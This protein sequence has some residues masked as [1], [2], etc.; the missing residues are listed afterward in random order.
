MIRH[1][2]VLLQETIDHLNLK[3]DGR[4]IDGTLGG[5]GHTEAIL[6]R[7]PASQVLAFDADS[8]AI[9]RAAQR[10]NSFGSR[11]KFVNRNFSHLLETARSQNFVDVDGIVLDLGLSSDQMD[12]TQRGFGFMAGGPLDMRFDRS[13]GETAADLIN[14]LDQDELADL[15]FRY[16]EE[17]HSRKI[18]RSIVQA[19]PIDSAEK[20]ADVIEKAIG[21]RGKIHPATLTFQALRIAVNDELGSLEKVLPQAVELLKSGGRLAIIS[22]H[23]LEDR[24]VKEFFR[25]QSQVYLSQKSD[26]LGLIKR[27]PT[28]KIITRKPIVPG[29]A[30]ITA[31]SRSRRAKLRVAE[32]I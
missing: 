14:T 2:T 5:G 12:D 18:A 4:Y 10:L 8:A 21:R 3:P 7:A 6:T 24:S 16:G 30:E 31:N 28:L 25:E 9:D 27:E 26:P 29:E 17:P 22:F 23:S 20:L 13:G 1:I 32:K 19:R 11:V 15:I